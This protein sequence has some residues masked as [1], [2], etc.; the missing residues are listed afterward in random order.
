MTTHDLP[1]FELDEIVDQLKHRPSYRGWSDAK[2]E[3][4]VMEYRKFLALCRMH[5]STPIMPG[6]DVDTIWH[7]HILNSEKYAWDCQQYFGYFLHHRPHSRVIAGTSN[8]NE[9]WL[10][11]LR[12]YEE[13]FCAEPPEQWLNEMSICNGGCDGSKCS[14]GVDSAS[15]AH[16]ASVLAL[17]PTRR[18]QQGA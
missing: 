9:A 13:H 18:N 4:A 5:P 10:M 16:T 14:P 6:R 2:F 7:Q 11:T 15:D 3:A 12:L 1:A 17:E 8:P